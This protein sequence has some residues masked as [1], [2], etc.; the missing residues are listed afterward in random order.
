MHAV[1]LEKNIAFW[2]RTF[3]KQS[4]RREKKHFIINTENDTLFFK[5]GQVMSYNFLIQIIQVTWEII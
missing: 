2:K 5:V 4:F 3:I 1:L